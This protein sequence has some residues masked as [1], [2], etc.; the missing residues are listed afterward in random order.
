MSGVSAR[1]QHGASRLV[2]ILV[3]AVLA[4]TTAGT[5]ALAAGRSTA[6]AAAARPPA[7][8]SVSPP[9]V[10]PANTSALYPCTG[11]GGME[12]WNPSSQVLSDV[13]GWSSYP[14][15]K[16]GNGR[17]DINWQAN[18]FK[19][20]SWY[21]LLHSLR[22]LGQPIRDWRAYPS[23]YQDRY[24][25][26]MAVVQDWI[27]DNPYPWGSEVGAGSA[28]M[29]RT[30]TLLCLREALVRHQ[31][32]SPGW[33]DA[34]LVQHASWLTANEWRDHN[35]G[36]D[37]NLALLGVGCVLQRQSDM[38]T[39]VSRLAATISRVVDAQGANNEQSTG[40]ANWNHVLW[41]KVSSYLR[42]CRIDDPGAAVIPAKRDAIQAFLDRA[43]APDGTLYPVGDT[44]N[45][46]RLEAGRSPAQRWVHSNGAAGSPPAERVS[47]Y[48]AGFVFGRSGW[49][50][51]ARP[52]SQESGYSLRFGPLRAG[53]GHHDHMSLTWQTR[54]RRIIVDPGVGEYTQDAWR[55]YATGATAHNM[56]LI[57]GMTTTPATA[58]SRSALRPGAD[59]FELK[60]TVSAGGSRV[61]GVLFLSDPDVVLVFDR[62][63]Y[64]KAKTTFRQLWH[65]PPD[66]AVSVSKTGASARR[67]GQAVRTS[68]V[69][70]PLGARFTPASIALTRGSTKPIQGWYWADPMHR[71]PAPVVT[72]GRTGRSAE[73][74]T[75]VIAGTSSSVS[76]SR[77]SSSRR[78]AL[79]S[80][81]SGSSTALVRL[82]SDGTLSRIG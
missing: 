73:F 10:A 71:V 30:N 23:R 46:A 77:V 60:D 74:L 4:V 24:Q 52:Q 2:V 66:Q 28:T 32:A 72:L 47:V 70:L 69:Q 3:T 27:K 35:I 16:V 42:T 12:T 13:Y 11:F 51:A 37:R 63:R 80:I 21:T 25:H 53:H 76:A 54:G 55:S 17:G 31:G 48:R 18:P 29:Y 50:G 38:T 20:P 1:R 26:V 39:V 64:P 57:G 78:A 8:G 67:T 75:A 44:S 81:R 6:A 5:S 82:S 33:L 58:L 14:R 61:R 49:G 40:Y 19:Q 9:V 43:T 59:F 36:T 62:L 22:W 65:L 34:S 79:Y 56:P 68:I 15:V 7:V 41:G 45:D